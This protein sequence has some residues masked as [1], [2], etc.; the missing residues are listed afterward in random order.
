MTFRVG[1]RVEKV[2]GDY[3]YEGTVVAIFLKRSGAVRLVVEDHR[4]LLFIFNEQSLR[5]VC[6]PQGTDMTPE[7]RCP[8]GYPLGECCGLGE[9]EEGPRKHRTDGETKEGTS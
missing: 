8:H 3:Q 5:L 1:D 2:G 6:R 7:D 4:G 9:P